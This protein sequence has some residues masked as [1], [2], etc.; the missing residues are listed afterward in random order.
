MRTFV[1]S[2]RN[3]RGPVGGSGGVNYK[4]YLASKKQPCSIDIIHVFKDL[5]ID[6]VDTWDT[7][8]YS[9]EKKTFLH[10][11]IKAVFGGNGLL[12]ILNNIFRFKK[13]EQW[14]RK[15]D[16][17]YHFNNDD[18]YILSDIESAYAFIQ[19]FKFEHTIYVYHQQGSLYEEWAGFTSRNSKTYR[20]FLDK[21]LAN[22]INSVNV[23]AFP[24]YGTREALL[25]TGDVINT[26]LL[27]KEYCI[28]YNGVDRPEV[29]HASSE[30]HNA[31]HWIQSGDGFYKFSTV[32]NLNY[33]KGVER[34]P[35]LLSG[36]KNNGIKFKWI[37]I[38]NGV[39][40]NE[41]ETEINKYDLGESVYWIKN[42]VPHDDILTVLS[43]TDFYIMMHRTSIFDFSTIEAMSYG[44]IPILSDVGGNKEVV[45]DNSGLLVSDPSCAD[46]V[47]GYIKSIDIIKNKAL[48][49]KIQE[50]NFSEEAFFSRYVRLVGGIASEEK[51]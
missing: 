50:K 16:D 39:K 2:Y 31:I 38:G 49:Q 1:F 27:N 9:Q 4:L 22:A 21:C 5:I 18:V 26:S 3:C 30:I 10:S 43:H 46:E 23:V 8:S 41:L 15:V 7:R 24:S 34:I 48:N 6:K 20:S 42:R 29:I 28:L 12:L 13:A 32:S 40:A 14:L 33:A 11:C 47:I 25:K 37:L 45:F 36:L 51:R 44:N 35:Q 19:T 17:L